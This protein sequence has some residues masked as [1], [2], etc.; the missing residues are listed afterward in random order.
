MSCLDKIKNFKKKKKKPVKV[1]TFPTETD[2][3]NLTFD[4]L[5][6]EIP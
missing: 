5:S 4:G 2:R 3:I 1:S 6:E